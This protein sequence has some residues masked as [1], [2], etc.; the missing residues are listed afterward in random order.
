[1]LISDRIDKYGRIV[2]LVYFAFAL[3]DHYA[4]IRHYLRIG[5][6]DKRYLLCAKDGCLQI[7]RS[8]SS[9]KLKPLL[10]FASGL[11]VFPLAGR[12]HLEVKYLLN[13]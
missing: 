10:T 3:Y 13:L 6:I 9:Q 2:Q 5:Y 11:K 7:I 4:T 8:P 1:V 12:W